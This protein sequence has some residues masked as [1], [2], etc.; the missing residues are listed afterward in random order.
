M[1]PGK[2]KN[3]LPSISRPLLFAAV[4][5]GVGF[6]LSLFLLLK[7]QLPEEPQPPSEL[8]FVAFEGK[9]QSESLIVREQGL[10]FDSSPLFMPTNWNFSSQYDEVAS[11]RESAELYDP[12]P[13][14]LMLPEVE[15][16]LDTFAMSSPSP[17]LFIPSSPSFIMAKLGRKPRDSAREPGG[18]SSYEVLNIY[19]GEIILRDAIPESLMPLRPDSVWEP[20]RLY[21]NM[22]AGS[23]VG[24]PLIVDSS[25][26]PE[27]DRTLL[28]YLQNPEFY[29][30]L[31]D[32]Y[33]EIHCFP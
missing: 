23:P 32:G 20:V 6:H 12:F 30:H 10:L 25:G 1:T 33:F 17:E 29:R 14:E 21:L 15:F 28:R 16:P 9:A 2:Q 11:L 26:F 4:I 24:P 27:W 8:A 22:H 5:V 19:T 3:L 18:T 7:I 31:P 13:P